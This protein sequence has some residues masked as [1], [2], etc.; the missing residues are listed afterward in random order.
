MP[1]VDVAT[2]RL[3]HQLGSGNP[4]H[5]DDGQVYLLQQS[6]LAGPDIAHRGRIKQIEVPLPALY[7]GLLRL[8]QLVVL[9]LEFNLMNVQF[10]ECPLDIVL[11]QGS[12]VYRRPLRPLGINRAP[13]QF[14][15]EIQVCLLF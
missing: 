6:R 3:T 11:G 10:V 14:G 1:R 4:Q 7:Q 5:F 13:S 8:S 15:N 12:Q 2:Q 9:H